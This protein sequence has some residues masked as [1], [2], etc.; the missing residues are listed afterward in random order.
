VAGKAELE[1]FN[2]KKTIELKSSDIL[3]MHRAVGSGE[4]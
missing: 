3:S 2:P 1:Q 4:A